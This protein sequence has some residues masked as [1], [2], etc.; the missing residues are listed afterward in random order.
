[1]ALKVAPLA[2]MAVWMLRETVDRQNLAILVGLVFALLGDATLEVGGATLFLVGVGFNMLSLVS[3]TVYFVRSD[4]SLDLVRV[5][6][7]AV[8]IGGV[9][10]FLA[11]H[12]GNLFVPVLVYALLYIVFLWRSSARL[13][14]PDIGPVSQW[15]CFTSCLVITVSDSF[16]GLSIALPDRFPW[17]NPWLIL[18][19]WW[20]GQLLMTVTAEVRE[21]V[22]R[23][24]LAGSSLG[25]Q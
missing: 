21:R 3:Y 6:P 17:A 14:D 5:V 4:P 12:L 16:L 2:M 7:F 23:R 8:V 13:G 9:F 11:P 25:H 15:L 10:A 24:R 19:L 22:V 1:V 20:L 18:S